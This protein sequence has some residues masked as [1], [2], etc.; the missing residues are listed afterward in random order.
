VLVSDIVSFPRWH[1]YSACH[2]DEA[3]RH[4][5]LTRLLGVVTRRAVSEPTR[6]T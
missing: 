5:S 3:T 4:V 1:A 2:L 6:C